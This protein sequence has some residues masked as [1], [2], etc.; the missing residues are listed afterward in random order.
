M[1]RKCRDSRTTG[2]K[3]VDKYWCQIKRIIEMTVVIPR[4]QRATQ[5]RDTPNTAMLLK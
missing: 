1:K 3:T 5:P 2:D 4:E